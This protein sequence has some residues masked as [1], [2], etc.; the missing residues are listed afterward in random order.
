MSNLLGIEFFKKVGNVFNMHK[1][2]KHKERNYVL[3]WG[4]FL[5]I[6]ETRNLI[7]HLLKIRISENAAYFESIIPSLALF[8]GYAKMLLFHKFLEKDSK[9]KKDVEITKIK[10]IIETLLLIYENPT[11]FHEFIEKESKKS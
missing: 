5:Q 7:A 11:E 3:S 10:V 4:D 8:L 2:S 9:N 6:F 1:A